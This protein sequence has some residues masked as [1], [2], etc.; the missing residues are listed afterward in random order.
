MSDIRIASRYALSLLELAEQHQAL[1]AVYADMQ[2][3]SSVCSSNKPF[4][5]LLRN[6][7]V[8]GDAKIAIL[9]KAFAGIHDISSRFIKLVVKKHREEYLPLI[10][11]SFIELFRERK[12]IATAVV[13]TAVELSADALKEISKT[14]EAKTKKTINMETKVDASLIGGL[15]IRIG[16]NLYDASLS[17]KIN[18]LKKELV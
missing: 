11:E 12:N 14:L 7:V 2:L 1:D 5:L 13:T 9:D 4:V 16:D 3:M 6:P 10:S 15:V 17:G 18:K 8:K